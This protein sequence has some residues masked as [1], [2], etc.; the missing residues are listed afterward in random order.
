MRR[1]CLVL[2]ISKIVY[3]LARPFSETWPH[4]RSHYL[5]ARLL[6]ETLSTTSPTVTNT[7]FQ[8]RG[9]ANTRL[10]TVFVGWHLFLHSPMFHADTNGF[11]QIQLSD[12]KQCKNNGLCMCVCV[13]ALSCQNQT[14]DSSF[15]FSIATHVYLLWVPVH[16]SNLIT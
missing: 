9:Q 8:I 13:C 11:T 10:T 16:A 7:H 5:L 3:Y 2:A 12:I 14:N 6:T 15:L 1:V 4:I